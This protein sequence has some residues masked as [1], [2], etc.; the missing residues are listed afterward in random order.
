MRVAASKL[1][2]D[3]AQVHLSLA[4]KC[5]RAAETAKTMKQPREP[6]ST[7]SG[8]DGMHNPNNMGDI[9]AT[10]LNIDR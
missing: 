1:P 3:T 4:C 7:V 2:N 5:M 10:M 6:N 9:H 8:L